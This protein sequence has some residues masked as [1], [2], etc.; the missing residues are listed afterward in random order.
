MTQLNNP[1]PVNRAKENE[2]SVSYI[3]LRFNLLKTVT[4]L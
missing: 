1:T 3:S 2:L 4:L